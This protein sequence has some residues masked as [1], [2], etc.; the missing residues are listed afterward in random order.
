MRFKNFHLAHASSLI[1]TP[2][3]ASSRWM[4]PSPSYPRLLRYTSQYCE[5][6]IYL[7]AEEFLELSPKPTASIHAV[8]ISNVNHA[9]ALY[10]QRAAQ[11]ADYPVVWDYH[12]VLVTSSISPPSTLSESESRFD[13]VLVWD[14]DTRL[15]FP[16]DFAT[17]IEHTFPSAFK[18]VHPSL[19]G[20]DDLKPCV[21]AYFFIC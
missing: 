3:T 14:Y 10:Q 9:V 6:N 15:P 20:F 1:R 13:D 19:P 8:F 7:L 16:C 11:R 4:L 17:Y 12:V 18:A 5:E 21:S 2:S